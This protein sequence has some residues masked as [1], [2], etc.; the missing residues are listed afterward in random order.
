[1]K[2]SNKLLIALVAII[3]AMVTLGVIFAKHFVN[4]T[5]N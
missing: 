3:F 2:T 1:M 5:V 4:I